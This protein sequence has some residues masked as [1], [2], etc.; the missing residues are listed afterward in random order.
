M[1]LTSSH[2][3]LVAFVSLLLFFMFNMAYAQR[4]KVGLTLAGGGA[5]GLAHIGILKAIDSAGLKI[6]YLTGTSMG[7]VV[8]SI[9]AAGYSGNDIEQIARNIDWG[10]LFKNSPQYKNVA[11]S[12]KDEFGS[13][14]VEVPLDKFKIASSSGLIDPEEIWLE[15]LQI[16]YPVY[17]IKDFH[18]LNIPFECLA[19]NVVNGDPVVLHQGNIVAAVRASMAIPT[20]FTPVNYENK[21]LVDGGLVRNFPVRYAKDMGASYLIGVSLY[22]GL[23]EKDQIKTAFDVFNQI[24]SYVDAAD[25]VEEKK[26]CNI[27]ISP[28]MGNYTAAS[29]GDYEKIIQI[30]LDEGKKMYPVFKHLADSLNSIEPIKYNPYNRLK[31]V[32]PVTIDSIEVVGVKSK[33]KELLLNSMDI[34]SGKAY[35]A[36]QLR[37]ALSKAYYTLNFKY[38]YYNLNP[39]A[40]DNHASIKIIAE[41]NSK[42]WVKAGLV[43]STFT[44]ASLD[45]NYTYR[46]FNRYQNRTLLSVSIGSNYN[47]IFQSRWLFGEHLRNQLQGEFNVTGLKIPIFHGV[48]K[49]LV[50]T[51]NYYSIGG[52]FMRY[53]GNYS[54]IG[55]GIKFQYNRYSP[56]IANILRYRGHENQLYLYADYL[57]NT[58]NSRF[59][60]TEGSSVKV[61]AGMAFD[62]HLTNRIADTVNVVDTSLFSF[63]SS[64]YYKLELRFSNY[65]PLGKGFSLISALNFGMLLNFNGLYFNQFFLGGDQLFIQ[66]QVPF[67]GLRDAQII[68]R[69]FASLLIGVQTNVFKRVYIQGKVNYGIFD[70]VNGKSHVSYSDASKMWGFGITGGY[71]VSKLPIQVSFSYSPNI[72]KVYG[73]FSLGYV[74]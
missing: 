4:P 20:V 47:G 2:I 64:P 8:G 21:L 70:F 63:D 34:K 16:L 45:L 13:Y 49:L 5:K 23:L 68:T 48:Q 25:E 66:N 56:D 3:V 55:V 62:R 53:M 69:S 60:P 17:K 67:V 35:N 36:S 31:Q 10:K 15:F 52:S 59:F 74:F 39:S 42:S 41:E 61:Q 38:I 19:T 54:G 28:P 22:A 24:T 37:E 71:L 9:Y 7:A 72:K 57:H 40:V 1:K 18:R 30:G 6:D 12:E 50:Y 46:T 32:P 44:G 27:L 14:L 29:F 65:K 33:S 73:S 51:T 26:M 58:L 11:L 43:Y